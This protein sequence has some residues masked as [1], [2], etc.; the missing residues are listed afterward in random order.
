MKNK[1]EKIIEGIG[2]AVVIVISASILSF[3]FRFLWEA[4]KSIWKVLSK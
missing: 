4:G 3:A 2:Y 1:I